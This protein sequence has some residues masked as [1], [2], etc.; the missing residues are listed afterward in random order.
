MDFYSHLAETKCPF[1][2]LMG[3]IIGDLVEGHD[4]HYCHKEAISPDGV[5]GGHVKSSNEA[6]LFLPVKEKLVKV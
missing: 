1:P 5:C 3:S 2:P 6:L 4:A